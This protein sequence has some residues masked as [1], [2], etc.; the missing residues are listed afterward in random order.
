MRNGGERKWVW[1]FL[2][3][4]ACFWFGNFGFW[5]VSE[6]A[7][8]STSIAAPVAP[9]PPTEERIE[10]SSEND[11]QER[12]SEEQV[13]RDPDDAEALRS[14]MEAKIKA[15]KLD[16]VVQ[17]LDRLIELEPEDLEWPLLKANI[18]SHNGELEL[19]KSEFEAILEKDPL[20]VEAYHGL[21]MAASQSGEK[22][23]GMVRRVEGRR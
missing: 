10:E 11:E 4:E 18:H 12:A 19:T 16:E 23:N 2:V 21:V 17:V 6:E 22:L 9:P 8:P 5:G 20:R 7:L 13:S 3:D 1:G 15:N 14:L